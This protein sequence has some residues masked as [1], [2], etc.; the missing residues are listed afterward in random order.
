[1]ISLIGVGKYVERSWRRA[2]SIRANIFDA[3]FLRLSSEIQNCG[4]QMTVYRQTGRLSNDCVMN[5]SNG[6]TERH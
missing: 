5:S 3:N 4:L 6:D 2:E 1:M